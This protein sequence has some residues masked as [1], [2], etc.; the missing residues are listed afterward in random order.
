MDMIR[1]PIGT[2]RSVALKRL[3][4]SL[5]AGSLLPY[6]TKVALHGQTLDAILGVR[7]AIAF[8]Q[9]LAWEWCVL[10]MQA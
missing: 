3:D 4:S 6:A 10:P 5:I 2:L 8:L 9:R 7:L 1:C